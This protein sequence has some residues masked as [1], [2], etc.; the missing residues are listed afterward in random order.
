MQPLVVT[1]STDGYTIVAGERRLRAAKLAKLTQV[2]VVLTDE[3]DNTR[4]LEMA[5]IEN[6]QRED[7]NA[8]EIAEAYYTLIDKFG[9]TQNELSTRVGKSRTAVANTLRL[10]TLPD[11]IKEMIR[12]GRLSEGHARAILA[13]GTPEAMITLAR[14]V[15]ADVLPVREVERRVKEKKSNTAMMTRKD[16]VLADTETYLKQL[17]G[18]AVRIHHGSKKG[19]IEIEYYGNQDLDRLLTLFHRIHS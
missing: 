6:V 2:P 18:T 17:F 12:D 15:V 3:I 11:E 8:L 5:L 4:L 7:L 19:H 9:L 14:R 10:L 16:P 13:A 1:K